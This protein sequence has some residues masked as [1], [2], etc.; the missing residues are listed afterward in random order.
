VTD[1][2][3]PSA[4]AGGNAQVAMHIDVDAFWELALGAYRRVAAAML[5]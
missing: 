4:G 2:A 1:F 3:A 5:S